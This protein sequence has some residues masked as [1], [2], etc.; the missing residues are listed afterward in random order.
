ME[1]I[2]CWPTTPGPR[3]QATSYIVTENKQ[4]RYFPQ[5]D[6]V[7]GRLHFVVTEKGPIILLKGNL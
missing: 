1:C 2:L 5:P 7:A 6:F 3:A 4:A